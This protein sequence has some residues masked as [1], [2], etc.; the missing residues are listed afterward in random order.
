M[1]KKYKNVVTIG[2][3]T[4]SFML[5]TGLKKYPINLSAI[6]SMADDGG[7]AGAL[8]DELGVL[9]PGDVRQCLV[10]LSDSS[11]TLR[12]LMNYRFGDGGLKGHTFG[13]L[14]LSALEKVSGSFFDGIEEASKILNV[15]GEV[16]PVSEENMHLQIELKNGKIL[17]GEGQLDRS[18]EVR[19]C[20]IRSVFL[21]AGVRAHRKAVERILGADFVII[22]PGD[23]YG[24]ILPNLMVAGIARALKKT[25]AK[26]VFN[27]NLT[28]K[29]GQTENFSIDGYVNLIERYIGAGRINFVVWNKKKMSKKLI[30][31]YEERE[32]ANSIVTMGAPNRI[33]KYKLIIADIL[34]SK[35]PKLDRLDKIAAERSF[36]R[37]D[38]DKLAKVLMDIMK[39]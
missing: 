7:S 2:G 10:A 5:L 37:H 14:F 25:K 36:V 30:E 13:N 31:K 34:S 32:G 23:L 24:S 38:S 22:G 11:Q 19:L 12:S 21:K 39:K 20:G 6:V 1:P 3:G 17:E 27:C 18:Q 4:G 33:G 26:I 15:R 28:N 29:K 9:P 16:I 8:R 35:K